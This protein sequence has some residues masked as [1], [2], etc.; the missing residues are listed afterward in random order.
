MV[1]RVLRAV[2]PLAVLWIGKL[3]IDAVQTAIESGAAGRGI[4][5]E[6]L[7]RLV[8]IEL[9]LAVIGEGLARLSS[10]YESLLGDLFSNR[11]S[12]Q[13]MEHAATLDLEQFEN[14]DIYD[15]LERARRQTVARIG[16]FTQ[17]L[18]TV[19]DLITLVS[20]AAALVLYVP[21]L[22][23]LLAVSVVPSF[24]GESYY[25]SKGYSLLYSWTPAAAPARLPPLYRRQRRLGQ[26]GEA[27]R[28][29]AVPGRPV[30][31]ALRRVL[32]GQQGPG[33]EAQPG[34][35]TAG[36]PG[37]PGILRRL[38]RHH[39]P[40]GHRAPGARQGV[41]HRR[42]DLPGGVVPPEPGPDPAGAAD[43]VPDLRAEPLPRRPLQLLHHPA[44][45]PVRRRRPGRAA[46][47]AT[48]VSLRG[49]GIPVPRQRGMGRPPPRF[50]AGPRG[51]P[52]AGR[53]KRCRQDDAGEAAGPAL[54]PD[55]KAVSSSTGWT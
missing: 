9:L 53:G 4:A 31:E 27:L 37:Y 26:G 5:R 12:V 21:W 47:A 48:G 46:P 36:R 41:H 17:L 13:L 10:L 2:V 54:R 39:L 42:A 6:T 22:L 24:L 44:P 28:A 30:R 19:Q 14:P 35:R 3:I 49:R 16:L 11:T 38:R 25:A 43:P 7:I 34:L 1:L 15:R 55:A 50:P 20:L 51:A 23:L 45:H 40:H 33:H 29:L 18:G 8:V 52:G 32:P